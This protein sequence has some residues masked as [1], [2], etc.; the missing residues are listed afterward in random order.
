MT[1]PTTLKLA[2]PEY[3]RFIQTYEHDRV[4]F[5]HDC[6][7]PMTGEGYAP[8][9]VEI[10]GLLDMNTHV[11]VRGPHGLGKTAMA[12]WV[13]LHGILTSEDVKVPTTASS[14]RQLTKFL[15]PEIHKWGQRLR[16]DR[17]GLDPKTRRLF[18]DLS[19]KLGP[20]QEAFAVASDNAVLI[21]G[22]H[23]NRVIYVFDESKSIP[24]GTWDAAEGAFS[25][26]GPDTG[27]E[28]KA[29]AISTPGD[30]QGKFYD[31]FARRPGLER[32]A[33]RHVTV[34]EAIAA[35][36]VSRQWVDNMAQEWGE[37]SA[38]FMTHVLGEFATESN[39]GLIPLTWVLQ[40]NERWTA[41][42]NSLADGD[43]L[44]QATALG[45]DVARD[46]EDRTAIA[47]R[48]GAVIHSLQYFAKQDTMKTAGRVNSLASRHDAQQAVIV[49]D[50][51]GVGGGVFDRLRELGFGDRLYSFIAG[52]ATDWRDLTGQNRFA[53]VRSA[54]WWHMRE[55][56]DPRN[57]ENICLPPDP[58]LTRDLTA[59][60]WREM[61]SGVIRVESKDDLRKAKRLGRSTDAAD[62]VIQAFWID[63]TR[64]H[65]GLFSDD[66]LEVM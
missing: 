65:L 35:R 52:G 24:D 19:I 44:G 64:I 3:R 25:A 32:W 47:L 66:G 57:E 48:F 42:M 54:A 31:I 36:R 21:E 4:A 56:L 55:L 18:N 62:A 6:L 51:V 53:D 30:N 37:A 10:M 12:S 16:W 14:W 49:V 17:I 38:R 26:A 28:A 45:V 27:K 2:K 41:V 1:P 43:D 39:E 33:T 34:E 58:I 59:P 7:I 9:Q 61:S 5:I 22:A 40:A 63:A 13:V 29:F 8:Y 15:W 11:A 46:G 50:V 23:A 60:R 20:T